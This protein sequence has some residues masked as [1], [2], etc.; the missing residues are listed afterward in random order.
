MTI[1][2]S[3]CA[4]SSDSALSSLQDSNASE[5][6]RSAEDDEGV[7]ELSQELA[8]FTFGTPSG[9]HFGE[10]SIFAHVRRTKF[11]EHGVSIQSRFSCFTMC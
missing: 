4:N 6:L 7:E 1:G 5:T 11:W 10:S 3:V 8:Q 2:C 9:T